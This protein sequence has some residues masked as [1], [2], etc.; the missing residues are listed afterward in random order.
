MSIERNKEES[1]KRGMFLLM[2]LLAVFGCSTIPERK[3]PD[4]TVLVFK[5]NRIFLDTQKKETPKPEKFLTLHAYYITVDDDPTLYVI[6]QEYE[7]FVITN[8][9]PGAHAITSI[10]I[11]LTSDATGK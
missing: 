7:Q 10:R 6:Q 4:D 8:L 3:K 5:V 1:M 9:K 2:S 11:R